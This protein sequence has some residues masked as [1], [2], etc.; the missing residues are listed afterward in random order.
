MESKEYTVVDLSD[1]NGISALVAKISSILDLEQYVNK[2]LFINIG[3]VSLKQSQLLS[4]KALIEAMNSSLA[5]IDTVSELT[6]AS[7]QSLGIPTKLPQE[8]PAPTFQETFKKHKEELTEDETETEEIVATEEEEEEETEEIEEEIIAE[9]ADNGNIQAQ[10]EINTFAQL[11][12]ANSIGDFVTD[13]ANLDE[14]EPDK[15]LEQE[16]NE[17]V[18]EAQ[19]DDFDELKEDFQEDSDKEN[20]EEQE[21]TSDY[22]FTQETEE[23]N[24]Y[25]RLNSET[26]NLSNSQEIQTA[27]D[28]T[29]G[30]AF[31]TNPEI[32]NN[33]EDNS[34][35]E[36]ESIE[37]T[38]VIKNENDSKYI[39]LDTEGITP[40]GIELIKSNTSDLPTLYL[41]QT[42]RSGQTVS[43]EGNIFIIGDAHPGSEVNATGDVTVWGILG[44]IVHAGSDGNTDAKV[45][46]LKLNPIQLRIANLYS[47]RNDTINVPYVQ[48]TNEFTPEEARI[49]RNQIVIYK[50]LRR[51]D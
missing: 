7:A 9:E 42:L 11:K 29:F 51:E 32:N 36:T 3:E 1:T 45:R 14:V 5:G 20:S 12:K 19:K 21:E 40:E 50:T 33:K 38:E 28:I 31:H 8:Q 10:E 23:E 15:N 24:I 35:E 6:L 2:K 46:A 44:G 22:L 27:L 16:T 39:L 17:F 49:D 43:Y 37:K 13:T 26:E 41:T 18:E 34:E 4:I 48:K 25:E 47:R 30:E